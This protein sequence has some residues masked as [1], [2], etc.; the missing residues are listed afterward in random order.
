VNELQSVIGFNEEM[1]DDAGGD[2]SPFAVLSEDEAVTDRL[3]PDDEVTCWTCGSEVDR[4]Q[5]EGIVDQLRKLSR[6]KTAEVEEIVADIEELI[7][8]RENLQRAQRERNRVERR[9]GELETEIQETEAVEVAVAELEN[10]DYSAVLD[11]H[12]EANQLE[13]DL[14]RL[15]TDLDQVEAKIASVEER[16]D[17]RTEIEAQIATVEEEITDR[18]TRIQRIEDRAVESFNE[19]MESLLDRLEYA[20]LDR[21]WIERV[22][23]EVREGRRKD[24]RKVFELHVVRRTDSGTV[25]EDTVDNLSE[26]ER[27]V[28]GL[29]F[30]LA[31]YLAHEV[32]EEMPFMLLDS[33][34]AIDSDRI[35]TLV[36]YLAE[37]TEYLVVALLPEDAA[38]L[39]EEYQRIT[40]I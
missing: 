21:I 25:Y 6:E 36:E 23:R 5:I 30:A 26:S 31:G 28:T 11:L 29:V 32:Y 4:D 38:A 7:E 27:E 19:H 37:Y 20:N 40:E 1:L 2:D 9:L 3:V 8:Q 22:S 16:I 24:E 34:E 33:L 35:A 13:Y 15:E 39:S 18:R 14:G 17:E 12:R 10:E